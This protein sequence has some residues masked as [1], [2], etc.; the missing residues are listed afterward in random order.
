MVKTK[1]AKM[2]S[3]TWLVSVLVL[4]VIG[5]TGWYV[6]QDNQNTSTNSNRRSDTS[7]TQQLPSQPQ[8]PDPSEGGKYLVIKEWGVRVPF[9]TLGFNDANYTLSR[10]NTIYFYR[11]GLQE[12]IA[13]LSPEENEAFKICVAYP[14]ANIVRIK[15]SDV[16]SDPSIPPD[17]YEPIKQLAGYGY[18][19]APPQAICPQGEEFPTAAQLI[20][21]YVVG[22][23]KEK[24]VEIIQS[25]EQ[26]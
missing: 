9:S 21:E 7:S 2:P 6:W 17:T 19:I 22:P 10:D 14:I 8:Q 1:N 12:K 26:I 13:E 16:E 5:A 3:K 15:M 4:A 24:R 18:R 20:D 11:K 23:F 25:L